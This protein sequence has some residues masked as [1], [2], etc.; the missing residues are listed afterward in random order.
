MHGQSHDCKWSVRDAQPAHTSRWAPPQTILCCCH[1]VPLTLLLT[2]P[3]DAS[4]E[5]LQEARVAPHPTRPLHTTLCLQ[6]VWLLLSD[7]MPTQATH[8][9]TSLVHP[10]QAVQGR[11]QSCVGCT[12]RHCCHMHQHRLQTRLVLLHYPCLPPACVPV[13]A[14]C[15]CC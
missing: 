7:L 10:R 8:S 5:C 1:A 13:V 12:P 14:A 3:C 4:T 9:V 15:C 6:A 2:F 11:C